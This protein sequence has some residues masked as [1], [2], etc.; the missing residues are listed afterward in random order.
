MPA[1]L[2]CRIMV[3]LLDIAS[4]DSSVEEALGQP[5]RS[6]AGSHGDG[7]LDGI[8]IGMKPIRSAVD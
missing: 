7:G 6:F 3:T 5:Q 1:R 8:V 4:K 2:A